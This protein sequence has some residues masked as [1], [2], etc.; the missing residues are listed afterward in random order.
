MLLRQGPGQVA[1]QFFAS[2][3]AMLF[4]IE[5]HPAQLHDPKAGASLI[6]EPAIRSCRSAEAIRRHGENQPSGVAP[7]SDQASIR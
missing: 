6:P 2:V 4:C 7:M 5:E 1:R 3:R